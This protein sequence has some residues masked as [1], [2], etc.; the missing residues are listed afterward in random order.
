[1]LSRLALLLA[2]SASGVAA[3]HHDTDPTPWNVKPGDIVP[4]LPPSSGTPIGFLLDAAGDLHLRDE[5]VDKLK[6][7]DASLVAQQ[8]DIDTQLRAIEKPD[9]DLAK[10]EEEEH[11]RHNNAPGHGIITNADAGRLHEARDH[12]D[13]DA[14]VRAFALLEP[15]QQDV[16]RKILVD[17]GV[18]P[19]GDKGD[20]HTATDAAGQPLPPG[21]P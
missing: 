11:R 15:D 8:A 14:L 4:P 7:I 6:A 3:C 20:K 12:N 17:H 13:Q 10:E 9:K 5:Q 16:A 19:P 2:L 18:R 21:Q 1:V